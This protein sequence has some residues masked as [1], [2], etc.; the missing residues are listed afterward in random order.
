MKFT[1]LILICASSCLALILPAIG[2][3]QFP[4]TMQPRSSVIQAPNFPSS[5]LTSTQ[6]SPQKNEGF[7][8]SNLPNSPQWTQTSPQQDFLPGSLNSTS[9]PFPTQQSPALTTPAPLQ[10]AVPNLSEGNTPSVQKFGM[11]VWLL[12]APVCLIGLA[13]WTFSPNPTDAK[14]FG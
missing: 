3:V 8:Q 11:G 6:L 9:S 4:K 5:T 12:L 7:S 14:K 13:M 1:G 2:A 10:E